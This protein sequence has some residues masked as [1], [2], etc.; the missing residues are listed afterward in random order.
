LNKHKNSISKTY[1]HNTGNDLILVGES[2]CCWKDHVVSYYLL[3]KGYLKINKS[4]MG[5][6]VIIVIM[7]KRNS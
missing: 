7:I 6:I 5:N 2:N 1:F 3:K 4:E